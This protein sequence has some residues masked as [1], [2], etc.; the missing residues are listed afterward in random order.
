V[1]LSTLTE[2]KR[3]DLAVRAFSAS[4]RRLIVIGDGPDRARLERLAGPS[5]RFTGHLDDDARGELLAAAR[6]LVFPGEEDFGIAAVEA[7]ACGTPVVAYGRG[8][9]TEI[10]TPGESGV[11]FEAESVAALNAAVESL[12]ALPIRREE[13]VASAERFAAPHFRDGMHDFVERAR[14]GHAARGPRRRTSRPAAIPGGR[15]RVLGVPVDP[16]TV[17]E[18]VSRIEERAADPESPPAYVIKPYVEFFGGRAG[19]GVGEILEGA[20]LSLAD[21]VAVQWAAAYARRSHHRPADL[22]LSLAA[23]AL[24]PGSVGAVVPERVAGVTLTLALLERCRE[25]G[26]GVFLVG[27]PKHHPITHTAGHLERALPGLR[28]LGSAP[29]RADRASETA[30]LEELRRRRPDV[31]L[32]G[33][34]FPAQERLM[35]RLAPR[36]EHGVLIGEGGSFDYREL[37]GGI[38]RAP[39]AVR[40]L[41]LEWFWR[42]LREPRRLGRQLAIPR[43][44]LAV[45]RQARRRDAAA[46]R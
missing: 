43:F 18:A 42:L 34:G 7:L 37:G 17:A 44:V 16:L 14:A 39:A 27:S 6:A 21:G 2:Y 32:V 22:L 41:G 8:G 26:L 24:R 15:I 31:I 25:R 13:L 38:R 36:L 3:I 33:M 46:P 19:A 30:L 28:V 35:A 5:V 23:I 29:G 10:V 1:T 9:L 40:G 12:L 11:F 4:G 20:W 45:Q